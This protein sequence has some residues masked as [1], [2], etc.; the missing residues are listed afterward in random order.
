MSKFLMTLT[1]IASTTFILPIDTLDKV[2]IKE[3]ACGICHEISEDFRTITLGC[4]HTHHTACLVEQLQNNDTL[5]CPTCARELNHDERVQLSLIAPAVGQ[6]IVFN[7]EDLHAHRQ[8]QND[9]SLW[10]DL[11]EVLERF[12]VEYYV[13]FAVLIPWFLKLSHV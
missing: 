3:R 12:P 2:I 7:Q 8:H 9:E 13:S 4:N 5:S 11:L 10:A 1:F 6:P